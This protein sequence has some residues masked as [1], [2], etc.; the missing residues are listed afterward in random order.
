MMALIAKMVYLYYI[1]FI[2]SSKTHF[3]SVITC[4]LI[5]IGN[6]NFSTTFAN[7]IALGKCDDSYYGSPTLYCNLTGHWN[8]TINGNPCSSISLDFFFPLFFFF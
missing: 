4:T 3:N 2:F 1:Y 7:N 5:S 6:A 8:Q